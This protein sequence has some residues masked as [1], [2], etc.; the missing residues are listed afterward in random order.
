MDGCFWPNSCHG[1]LHLW[2]KSL[3]EDLV[4][5]VLYQLYLSLEFILSSGRSLGFSVA[6]FSAVIVLIPSCRR[7]PLTPS[8]IPAVAPEAERAMLEVLP[9]RVIVFILKCVLWFNLF[10]NW[11]NVYICYGYLYIQFVCICRM[12]SYFFPLTFLSLFAIRS[13]YKRWARKGFRTN[14][15]RLFFL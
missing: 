6:T 3:D 10:V 8:E 7:T 5:A 11:I 12:Y 15:Q 4:T 14:L 2:T 1:A 13:S 9:K